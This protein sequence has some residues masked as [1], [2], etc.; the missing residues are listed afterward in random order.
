VS[1]A[2]DLF[3]D[4]TR[5]WFEAA[6]GTPTDIQD[7]GWPAV[8][9]GAHTLMAAPTGSGKTLAAFLWAI[10]RLTLEE[11]PPAAERCRVLYVSPLKALAVDIDRNLRAPLQ[12]VAIER[13]ARGLPAIS[14][15]AALRTGDTPANERRDLERHP[16]DILI[17][18]PESLFLLLTSA[19]RRILKPIRWVI[20]DEIHAVAA[21]K[22]GAHLALSL[23]RLAELT[24]SDPQRIGLSATVRPLDEVARFLGGDREV[25]VADAGRVRAVEVSVQ[26]PVE[27][28]ADLASAAEP[29]QSG[30]AHALVAPPVPRKS[31]WPALQERLLELVREHRSTIVFVNSRRLAERLAARLNEL[32]GEDL[33]RAHHGSIAREQ[34]LEIEDALKRGS[35]RGLVAT[36]SLELGIDMGAVD[37]VVQ[38]E[39]P[40]SVASGLQRV[41]R[42]GHSVGEVSRGVVLPKFRGDL[43]EAAAVTQRMLRAEIEALRVPQNPIDV[44]AQQLVAM[45]ALDE[46]RVEDLARVVRRSYPFAHLG[47]R[48]FQAVLDLLSGRYPST[49]FAELR[50]RLTWDRVNGTLRG[51]PGAQRLA[52]TNA[53]TIP[54]RGLYTV[55]LL[56]NGKRVG[57]LDEEMVFESRV[58]ETFVLGASTWRIADITQAQVLVTPAP[59]EPGK[60]AFWKGDAPARP[61]ELGR[62]LGA[63]VRELRGMSDGAAEEALQTRAGFDELAARNLVAFL[64]DQAE[65]TGAVPDDRTIVIERFRDEVGD[66]RVCILTPYGSRVHAPWSLALRSRLADRLGIEVRTLHADDGIV[67]QLPDVDEPPELSELLLEAEEVDELVRAELPGSALFAAAFRESAARALLLPRN[68]PGRRNPL[69]QQRQKGSELLQAASRHPDFPILAEAYREC[70]NDYFD[71]PALKELLSGV[72]SQQVRVVTVDT[73]RA[74]PFA[75]SLLFEYVGQYLY[76]GDQP[77]A[78]RRAQALALD[79]ELLQELLGEEELRELL[80]PDAMAELELELQALHPERFPRDAD[81]AHDLLARLGDLGAAELEARGV[82]AEWLT[83]LGS[84]RRALRVRIGKVQRWI[85][86]EDA[87]LYRDALGVAL[88]PGLPTELLGPAPAPLEQLL[89]R[90]ARTHVPFHAGEPAA[91]WGLP[92]ARV[93]EAL[94]SLVAAGRLLAGEFRPGGRGREYAHPE[95]LRA[96]RRRSLA[97]LRREVEAVPPDTLGRF[98][99]AWHGIGSTAPGLERLL[100]VVFQLQGL[101]LPASVLERDVLSARVRDYAPRLLDELVSMGEVVWAGQG[102]LGL[103]DGRVALYLRGELEKLLPE[104]S[105]PPDSELHSRLRSH[106]LQRGASFFRELQQASGEKDPDAVLDALWD[107][108]WAGEVTNDTYAP[109]R[110]LGPVRSRPRRPR[111]AGLIPP[112]AAGRW[113]L[114]GH[115][116][117]SATERWHAEAGVLLQRHGVLTREAV[118][119]EGRPGGFA[120]LYPVLRAMEEAGRVRRG[121]FIEG[122]GGSQFA[123]PGAVDRLRT[124]READ[125]SVV[126]LAATDPAQPYGA[127]LPWPEGGRMARQAGAFLVLEGGQLVCYLERGGRSLLSAGEIRVDHLR[128]LAAAALRAGKLEIQQVDGRPVHETELAAGLREAGFGASPRG[129]V[130]YPKVA[131]ASA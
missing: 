33:V 15:R 46:R 78:E 22:R 5:A 43:L 6:L 26:V 35:L 12:G 36:S 10:D 114:L 107:L 96:L 60:I 80:D 95:V 4:P 92:V 93:D 34:R 100:E 76:E 20:V 113:S 45:C 21:S 2:L 123:L 90:W 68:R 101:A 99:P 50:P 87:A 122:M 37:L 17:T 27:D 32:A 53:G 112:R 104:A 109:L 7:K 65:A 79:R 116:G 82:A 11:T 42:A 108:V 64:R 88:P 69:W 115:A 29:L 72:R 83:E 120:Q 63:L 91:R 57:E 8:A 58:G 41:G 103:S 117:A 77:L 16:P 110:G 13:E 3:S 130:L 61:A 105:A 52:V 23:E 49:E 14:L 25:A 48:A 81:E 125:G 131:G 38:V 56:E 31:I 75:A 44:L 59:G 121:Y 47:E 102:A 84:A 74:S 85:A 119:G 126:C 70:L 124:L 28:M 39:A 30:P 51:R 55:N 40:P 73:E 1:S 67:L 9:R 86:V 128:A 89:F 127:A 66:W 24:A 98:L 129:M 18:T 111:L 54:D 19:A 71:M 97:A 106:L 94:A 118:L 62:S